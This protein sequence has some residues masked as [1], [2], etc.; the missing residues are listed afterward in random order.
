MHNSVNTISAMEARKR[1]G[2]LL[3][4]TYYRGDAFIIERSGRAMAVLVPIETYARLHEDPN[5][6]PA[7]PPK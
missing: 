5:T 3:E 7:T 2:Q 6:P 4:E 1:F